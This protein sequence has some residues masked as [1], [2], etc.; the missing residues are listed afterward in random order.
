[1]F[2]PSR[3]STDWLGLPGLLLGRILALGHM[4]ST[5][6]LPITQPARIP[7]VRYLE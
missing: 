6:L 1:M 2:D 3:L 5:A 4:H 7:I